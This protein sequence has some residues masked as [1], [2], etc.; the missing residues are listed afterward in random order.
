MKISTHISP[1]NPDY[2]TRIKLVTPAE[3]QRAIE[4]R[5]AYVEVDGVCFTLLSW[6]PVTNFATVKTKNITLNAM[7]IQSHQIKF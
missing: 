2:K 6:H 3:I 1:F 4:D 7:I 5:R